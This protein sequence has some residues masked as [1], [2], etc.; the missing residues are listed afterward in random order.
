MRWFSL[1]L[2]WPKSARIGSYGPRLH[3]RPI[4]VFCI[5]T[6]GFPLQLASWRSW[7]GLGL[8]LASFFW[9]FGPSACS[10]L[11]KAPPD[12]QRR[13]PG[14]IL[15]ATL[16]PKTTVFLLLS[17]PRVL[18][19]SR[20]FSTSVPHAAASNFLSCAVSAKNA[21]MA[22]DPQKPM[23]FMIWRC[24][25]LRRTRATQAKTRRTSEPN[26]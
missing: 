13:P 24:C 15:G 3:R 5:S 25:L 17:L 16:P 23:F 9:P 20:R 4:P 8:F 1:A 14:P 26:P 18:Q 22:C 21:R 10:C 7:A 11:A 12:V 19:F 2:A 6:S